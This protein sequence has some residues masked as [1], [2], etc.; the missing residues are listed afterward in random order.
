MGQKV[1]GGMLLLKCGFHIETSMLKAS[2]GRAETDKLI[3]RARTA[4]TAT[5]CVDCVIPSRVAETGLSSL[6]IKELKGGTSLTV[7]QSHYLL[8]E[9]KCTSLKEKSQCCV[10]GLGLD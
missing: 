2:I 7:K 5:S 6:P 8:K 10:Q 1:E 3:R 4:S 9:D